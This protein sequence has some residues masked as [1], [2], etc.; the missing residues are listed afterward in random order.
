[1]RQ[2]GVGCV[3]YAGDNHDELPES[4]HQGASWIGKLAAYGLTNV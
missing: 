2:I 3:L 1:L 4:A